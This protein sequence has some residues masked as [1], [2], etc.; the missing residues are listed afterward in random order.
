MKTKHVLISGALTC[1]SAVSV[2]QT[3]YVDDVFAKSD[4][5][6]NADVEYG[7]NFYFLNLPPAPPGTSSNNPQVGP[8]QMDVYTPPVSDTETDRPLVILLHTGSFLPKY[9]NGQ[10]TGSKTDS[11]I[12]D[13]ANRF[14]M[15]G[16]VSAAINYRLGWNPL[17]PSQI[18][19]TAGI[20]NAVYRALHDAQTA[21][22]FF[23]KEASTY[24]IDPAKI[25]LLGQGSGGYVT[26]AY[27]FMNDQSETALPKFQLQ[28]GS[29]V[30]N[31]ALVGDVDG[32]GGQVNNYNH[33]GY[34]NQVA[35]TANLGGAL[36]DKSW[37]E[38]IWSEPPL[39]SIHAR[40]DVFAPFDSG[41][42][43]V[44][45]TGQPVVNVHG[46]RA[47]VYRANALGNND[48][49][50]NHT[51]SDPISTRAYAMNPKAQ[52]E[53]LFQLEIA[54]VSGPGE[55]GSPWEWWDS[56]SVVAE[57]PLLGQDGNAIHADGLISN[58]DM[59]ATK[60][61]LYSDTIVGFL[62]PRMKLVMD[63]PN[64]NVESIGSAIAHRVYP[65]PV[66][67]VCYLGVH[68]SNA[69][70]SWTLRDVQGRVVASESYD[71]AAPVVKISRGNLPAGVYVLVAETSMGTLA[72]RLMFE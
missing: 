71:A 3:R 29:S 47:A 68:E 16:Y 35:M 40:R 9:I 61:R 14:A 4:I 15:K 10:A 22:R 63:N 44:P 30:I 32:V 19:R 38:G 59:S 21:V 45:A 46:S 31:P 23:K 50:Q 53:G 37:M 12:V 57:A 52:Y 56:A 41:T 72:E 54:E 33:P 60:G 48:I 6:V 65:N 2:A 7:Q 49:W 70:H 64:L 55:D 13:L 1:I 69:I 42:V 27:G 5:V 17:A 67:D 62:I 66:S 20:L 25:F 26:L 39:A 11:S 18:E 34:S 51:F 58:P 28:D 43:I 24:G 36:G 8:L